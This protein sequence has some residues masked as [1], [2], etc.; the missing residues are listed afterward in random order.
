[1]SPL[2]HYFFKSPLFSFRSP[3]Q[4]YGIAIKMAKKLSCEKFERIPALIP[5]C[6]SP[7]SLKKNIHWT[8]TYVGTSQKFINSLTVCKNQTQIN[9]FDCLYART[10]S[11]Y[12]DK[13]DVYN[14]WFRKLNRRVRL[15]GKILIFYFEP[16]R[17]QGVLVLYLGTY[18]EQHR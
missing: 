5:R 8:L 11:I 2:I 17:K 16:N 18:C 15:K 13:N 14:Y 3:S 12:K 7:L 9:N 10:S 1:M 4:Q 6:N